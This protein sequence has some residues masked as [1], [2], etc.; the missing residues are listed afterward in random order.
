MDGH[1]TSQSKSRLD[2]VVVVVVVIVREG[3]RSLREV[4]INLNVRDVCK[5]LYLNAVNTR[6]IK[7]TFWSAN[8]GLNTVTIASS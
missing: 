6:K 2:V 7:C 5:S 3:C 8:V 4:N 1:W